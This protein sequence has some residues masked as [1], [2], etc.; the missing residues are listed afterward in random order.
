MAEIS[1]FRLYV[2]RA[3]YLFIVVGLG[4][5][6]WPSVL[7]HTPEWPLMSSVVSCLLAGVSILAAVGIFYPLQMLPVLFFELIGKS[8]WLVAVALPLWSAG[9]M[10]ART[11]STVVDCLVGVV[12][13]PIVIPWG[14]VVARYLRTPRARWT[15][16]TAREAAAAQVPS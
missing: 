11:S 9:A 8:I 2:L 1:L 10:D 15:N 6:I 12:L 13:V 14:F 5:T 4:V 3:T 16:R 7:S